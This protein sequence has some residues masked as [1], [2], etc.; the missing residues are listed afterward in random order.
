MKMKIVSTIVFI[1]LSIWS[2]AQPT[3]DIEKDTAQANRYYEAALLLEVG[4]GE[5]AEALFQKAINLYNKY[6]FDKK[7]V[8]IIGAFA[9][10]QVGQYKFEVADSLAD[11]ALKIATK[12]IPNELMDYCMRYVYLAKYR[13]YKNTDV[14][15]SLTYIL[16]AFD[17]SI[18]NSDLYFTIS[19]DLI[20]NYI[21]LGN[22]QKVDTFLISMEDNLKHHD[23]KASD[24]IFIYRGRMDYYYWVRNYEK[25]ALYGRKLFL[26]NDKYKRISPDHLAPTYI[27]MGQID[28]KLQDFDGAVKWMRKAMDALPFDENHPVYGTY[29]GHLALVYEHKA[30]Y[31]LADERKV[32]Y[33]LAIKYYQKEI[34][35][36]KE[37]DN[38]KNATKEAYISVG[39]CYMSLGQ[40]EKAEENLLKSKLYGSSYGQGLKLGMVKRYKGEYKES[41]EELQKVL[42]EVCTDF[43]ST[44]IY[45]NPLPT[46]KYKNRY[47]ADIILYQKATTWHNWGKAEKDTKKLKESL[48]IAQSQ[49]K[50]KE[51]TW[52]RI[53]GFEKSRFI[54]NGLLVRGLN[55]IKLGQYALYELEPSEELFNELFK[56]IEKL[57]GIQLIESL[58][59]STL[60]DTLYKEEQLLLKAIQYNSYQL[61]LAKSKQSQDTIKKYQEMLFEANQD[62]ERYVEKINT[63]YQKET[64]H[65]YNTNYATYQDV[66]AVLSKETIVI[67]Y[68]YH[69]K[70]KEG[71]ITVISQSTKKIMLFD[72]SKLDQQIQKLNELIQDPFAFQTAVRDEF[73]NI[74]HELYKTLIEPIE[75]ELEGKTKLMIVLEGQLFHLPFEL[76]LKSKEKKPYHELDFLI[77]KYAINYHYSATAFLKLQEKATVKDNS[78]LAFAPVF[79]KGETLNKATRS[80]DFLVDSLYN[81]IDGNEFVALPSTKKEVNTIAKIVKSNNGQVNILLQKNATKKNFAQQLESQ[82]YQFVH[83]A[84]HGL[85]NFKNPRLSALAC[86]S[87]DETMDNLLYA[88][89]IQFKNINADLVILSSC[90][91][92]IG[93]LVAGEGLIAL[94][95]S[96][97]Y[98]GAKNVLFSLWKVSDTHSSELMI[99]FYKNYFDNQSYTVALR[100]AK[101]KMLENPTSAQPK[102]WS[103]FVLMG[104]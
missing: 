30:D 60:P 61:D 26:D 70:L 84:T 29:Y 19:N 50:R 52:Q 18:I 82:S 5:K 31:Q 20:D 1:T 35:I 74:S 66:Q 7:Q 14:N 58:S 101:L 22:F 85:V 39:T 2:F 100:N 44:D 72:K 65:F 15:R 67:N 83:I 80:L 88:N 36:L 103:A 17:C 77:K 37:I 96:F 45:Q 4:D 57:K 95:R 92:G 87:K 91:S 59:L 42:L 41:L 34:D 51:A 73:I 56:T 97:I 99:D 49:L 9:Y 81:G 48:K 33:Q 104:E 54:V 13:F 90:E 69:P 27:L 62:M 8:E 75:S 40:Y 47:Y 24:W 55:L 16:K 32:A 25:A 102:F 86:Y 23:G 10:M 98:S 63:N 53:K 93:Q 43:Q 79:S 89:E 68:S 11:V 64:T 46:E 12:E 71:N 21:E 6:P 3:G 76:L 78:L 94:N 38:M 28:T